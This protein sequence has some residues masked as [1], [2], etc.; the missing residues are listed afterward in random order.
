MADGKIIAFFKFISALKLKFHVTVC[1]PEY[2]SLIIYRGEKR[3]K[4][5]LSLHHLIFFHKL[6]M[7]I[8]LEHYVT[9][10]LLHFTI[11][12]LKKNFY[13]LVLIG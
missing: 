7:F 11:A 10:P 12:E 5:T 4:E 3:K 1:S 6:F 8:K 2:S 13:V 9:F